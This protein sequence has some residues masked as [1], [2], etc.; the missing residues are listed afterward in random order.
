[1]LYTKMRYAVRPLDKDDPVTREFKSLLGLLTGDSASPVLWVVYFAD[2]EN[3]IPSHPDD[4][5][6]AGRSVSHAEQ[7][8]DVALMS[9]SPEGLQVKLDGF[10]RWCQRNF[11]T[12]SLAKTEWMAFGPLPRAMPTFRVN[13]TPIAATSSY[14]YVGISY[15]AGCKDF[16][17]LHHE[18]KT[19]SAR[20]ARDIL[21]M[22]EKKVGSLS[23]AHALQLYNAQVDPH[24]TFGCEVAIEC[25]A[26]SSKALE[27]VQNDFLRRLLGL[28][29]RS[30]LAPLYIEAGV[31]PVRYRRLLI[32]IKFIA[33][34]ARMDERYLPA[35]AVRDSFALAE[36]GARCHISD[37]RAAL[38]KLPVPVIV[39]D[40]TLDNCRTE[41]WVNDLE[42][43][44]ALSCHTYLRNAVV[45]NTRLG[46]LTAWLERC[47]A[48]PR[49]GLR[50]ERRPYLE[51]HNPAYRTAIL[52]LVASEHPFAIE[53]GRRGDNTGLLRLPRAARLCRLCRE[54]VEDEVHA[55][56][57]CDALQEL[58][59]A[60]RSF[61]NQAERREEFPRSLARDR[62]SMNT[63]VELL[64][65]GPIAPL[66]GKFIAMCYALFEE[67]P[68]YRPPEAFIEACREQEVS[69]VPGPLG[70]SQDYGMLWTI[71]DGDMDYLS[72]SLE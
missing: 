12:I 51:I 36:T 25:S 39:T 20:K 28:S 71:Q 21:F 13:G 16:F 47:P 10:F 22:L 52:R 18:S 40:L 68:L 27:N 65:A 11:M 8:D 5:V 2:I 30:C 67:R 64:Q 7:A 57:V 44:L 17:R 33:Y 45:T 50:L 32:A 48:L 70:P 23:M 43:R 59:D 53:R 26:S 35:A 15:S 31:V 14:K 61:W 56:L 38:E 9:L 42:A 66:L 58:S 69:F 62:T 34:A 63:L 29:S 41:K 54:E 6:L 19:S 49:S 3:A 55:I 37:V 60:R 46:V 4:V 72:G 1:M 24:L